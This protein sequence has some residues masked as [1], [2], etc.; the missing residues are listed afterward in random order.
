MSEKK[1][2]TQAI[3]DIKDNHSKYAASLVEATYV[4]RHAEGLLFSFGDSQRG[5]LRSVELAVEPQVGA[6]EQLYAEGLARNGLWLL[7]KWKVAPFLLW[8]RMANLAKERATVKAR[9]IA[10]VDGGLV[11]NIEGMRGFVPKRQ[12]DIYE[13]SDLS[14]FVG[15]DLDCVVLK[16]SRKNGD[17]ILSRRAVLEVDLLE[18]KEALLK[19]L[20]AGQIFDARVRQVVPYGVFVDI[21]SGVE[22]LVHRSNLTWG[23]EEPSQLFKEGDAIKVQVLEINESSGKISFDHKNLVGDPWKE[24]VQG[25]QLGQVLNGKVVTLANFGAFVSLAPGVEGMIHISEISWKHGLKHPKQV[26]EIGQELEVKLIEIDEEARRLK[27]SLKRLQENPWSLASTQFSV[28]E[29]YKLKISGIA[30]FGVFVSLGEHVDG[31]IHSTDIEWSGRVNH[32]DER[33]KVGD[34]VECRLLALDVEQE[35]ASLGIKHLTADPWEAALEKAKLGEQIDVTIK[36]IA[37]FGAFAEI[38]D[39]VL[40]LIHISEISTERI[41]SV[42]EKLKVGDEVTATVIRIEPEKRRVSLSLI[43]EP[44]VAEELVSTSASET[45]EDGEMRTT[46]LDVFPAE[47]KH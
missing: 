38:I 10:F 17:V 32:L 21:G 8:D 35:K 7:S 44:F 42:E 20:Q 46:L 12:I 30:D 4:E 34:E 23:R 9:V 2:L 28:G 43:A 31:L 14:E 26:L 15:K 13:P 36:R 5:V 27:L 11:A 45:V 47:L 39:G 29:N 41:E 37:R 22:G 19:T 18:A 16:F 1:N 6:V 40:G 3:D 33:F 24:H 25:L